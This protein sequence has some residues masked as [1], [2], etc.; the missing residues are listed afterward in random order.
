MK[1]RVSSSSVSLLPWWWLGLTFSA[2]LLQCSCL[3]GFHRLPVSSEQEAW[4][5]CSKDN[6]VLAGHFTGLVK[7]ACPRTQ[8]LFF[9]PSTL[10]DDKLLAHKWR[11]KVNRRILFPLSKK[12]DLCR[13]FTALDFQNYADNEPRSW[14]FIAVYI[15]VL[16]GMGEDGQGSNSVLAS[17]R[18]KS[19]PSPAASPEKNIPLSPI[20]PRPVNICWASAPPSTRF[21]PRWTPSSRLVF[22]SV[23]VY[24]ISNTQADSLLVHKIICMKRYS[25]PPKGWK[26]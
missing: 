24:G 17:S 13:A 26:V 23:S 10:L 3:L 25:W 4:S 15:H 6:G 7:T 16:Q 2:G 12:L 20:Q 19:S 18:E 8:L 11:R 5:S 1:I 14:S 9:L 21:M 22:Q